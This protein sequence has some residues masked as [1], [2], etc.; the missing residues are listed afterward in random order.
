MARVMWWLP[1]GAVS[2]TQVVVP[3]AARPVLCPA[4]EY[5]SS[6]LRPTWAAAPLGAVVTPTP[7]VWPGHTGTTLETPGT[8]S[9][10]VSP[11]VLSSGPPQ[12]AGAPRNRGSQL[13]RRGLAGTARSR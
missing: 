10:S 1:G 7:T 13:I 2:Y 11:G 5:G 12:Q 3:G 4:F 8:P 9:P 6:A